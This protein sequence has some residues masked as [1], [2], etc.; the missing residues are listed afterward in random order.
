MSL[1]AQAR[2][3]LIWLLILPITWMRIVITKLINTR[4]HLGPILFLLMPA[5]A[6]FMALLAQ[7][8]LAL[9]MY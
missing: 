9:A 5:T 1:P 2:I 6:H 4:L 3:V 7:L 8:L